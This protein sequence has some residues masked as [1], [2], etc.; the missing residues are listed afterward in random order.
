MERKIQEVSPE[1]AKELLATNTHNRP[2]SDEIVNQ[3]INDM[4]SYRFNPENTNVCLHNDGT[5][6]YGQHVLN[7]IIKTNKTYELNVYTLSEEDEKHHRRGILNSK[8]K[9]KYHP[10][11]SRRHRIR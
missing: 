5:L 11:H 8:S 9:Y 1:I 4:N 2:L 6:F 7:A 3:I 10:I